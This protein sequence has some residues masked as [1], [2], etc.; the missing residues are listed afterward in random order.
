MA[1]AEVIVDI[2]HEKLD[3]PFTYRIPEKMALQAAPG[4]VVEIPF[5]KGDRLIR[6]YVTALADTT[7]VPEDKLKDISRV[8]TDEET[9][10]S[11][12]VALAAWM[13]HTFGSTTIKAL[14]TVVP[15]Q[16]KY[17]EAVSSKVYLA[18]PENTVKRIGELERKHAAAKIRVLRSLLDE[19]GQSREVLQR[20]EKVSLSVIRGLAASGDVRIEEQSMLRLAELSAEKKNPD[21]LTEEQAGVLVSIRSEWGWGPGE[22]FPRKRPVLLHGITGS[23]KT[24]VYAELV[25]EVLREGRQAIVLIP[26][27]ALT[28]QTVE[29]FM[30]RFGRKVSFLHSRL[31][32]A[33]RYDQMKAARAGKVSVMVGPRSALFTPFPNLGLIIVDEEHEET[34]HS[35]TVP[36]YHV[37]DT[38][39]VRGQI[40][41]ARILFGSATP[42][43]EASYLAE[44]GEWL[45]TSLSGRYGSAVLPEC[46]IVDMREEIRAGNRSIISGILDEE[47]RKALASKEQIMLFLN[48]RGY[49]GTVTCRSCGYVVKCPHCDVSLTRHKNGRMICHYCGYETAAT[50]NCPSCGSP[51]FGGITTGTE[52]AEEYVARKYPDARVLRMDADTTGGRQGHEQILR[53]FEAGEADILIGTQMIVKGHD[54]PNVTLVGALLA[55]LSLNEENYRSSERTFQLLAQAAG[56][57]GRARK[58]GR[59][60]IQTYHPDHY[61]ITYGALQDYKSFYREEMAFRRMMKY[62]PLS[63]MMGIYGSARD[64]GRLLEAMK[65]LRDMIDRMDPGHRMM[66]LGPAPDQ[67]GRIRDYYRQVIYLRHEDREMLIRVKDRL[68]L[69]TAANRGFQDIRIQFDTGV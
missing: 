63:F 13:S 57:A 12:L 21:I 56:R 41:D 48:R 62:P 22:D 28:R 52:Q 18:D 14:K 66:A 26:E 50:K 20:N 61:A 32:G 7:D 53:A 24:V 17:R 64:E 65:H 43:L 46:C 40:E 67:V 16:K 59:A 4:S 44:K 39:L 5:G 45:Y 15:V 10:E 31:S 51:Y 58:T 54:F 25:E 3:H 1:Y 35:E 33:E 19:D 60:V 29:R 23:G 9:V 30:S 69:Y 49:T 68:E 2:A 42:S 8:L 36:R 11:R 55:D 34:Y 6:G 27:I 47:I 37:R 38:A